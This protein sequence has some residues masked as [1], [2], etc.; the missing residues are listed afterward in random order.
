M[1]HS[2]DMEGQSLRWR[3]GV[4]QRV[5]NL[6]DFPWSILRTPPP[7]QPSS[8]VDGVTTSLQHARLCIR[9][10]STMYPCGATMLDPHWERGLRADTPAWAREELACLLRKFP[11]ATHKDLLR[12]KNW[13]RFQDLQ[14]LFTD[15]PMPEHPGEFTRSPLWKSTAVPFQAAPLPR[16]TAISDGTGAGTIGTCQLSDDSN[17]ATITRVY[18]G[19]TPCESELVGIIQSH[20]SLR[21]RNAPVDEGKMLPD[22]QSAIALWRAARGPFFDP[23][24]R[25]HGRAAILQLYI[26]LHQRH[27]PETDWPCYWLPGHSDREDPETIAEE[28]QG[29]FPSRAPAGSPIVFQMINRLLTNKPNLNRG[30]PSPL[31][32]SVLLPHVPFAE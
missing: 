24:L 25:P 18:A 29:A 7:G 27:S 1:L 10:D 26:A 22:C 21:A 8:F 4:L 32:S 31:Y 13:P 3:L 23:M 17:M 9:T 15:T 20:A 14:R 28:D 2:R 19:D 12:R 11:N 6:P 16:F 30:N 5:R